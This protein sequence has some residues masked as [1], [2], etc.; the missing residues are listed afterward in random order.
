MV[1][2][3]AVIGSQRKQVDG[4]ASQTAY[5]TPDQIAARG[6]HIANGQYVAIVESM[7]EGEVPLFH[8]RKAEVRREAEFQQRGE[9]PI[10]PSPILRD[11]QRTAIHQVR[12]QAKTG[13]KIE[14]PA[15]PYHCPPPIGGPVRK[16]EP[17]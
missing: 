6:A 9:Y 2:R 7:L 3:R 11:I 12:C 17:G 13:V 4:R 8:Q 1:I 15:H 16:A 10:S 14:S 5:F